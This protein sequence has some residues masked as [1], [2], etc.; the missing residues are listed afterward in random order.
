[1]CSGFVIVKVMDA[2]KETEMNIITMD[3][4]KVLNNRVMAER[5][6][7]MRAVQLAEAKWRE[8]YPEHRYPGRQLS[9][10]TVKVLHRA[11]TRERAQKQ[12]EYMKQFKININAQSNNGGNYNNG[13]RHNNRGHNNRQQE[14]KRREEERKRKKE[15][16]KAYLSRAFNLYAEAINGMIAEKY[17]DMQAA[18]EPVETKGGLPSSSASGRTIKRIGSGGTTTLMKS[19]SLTSGGSSLSKGTT[20]RLGE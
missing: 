4:Y 8:T 18:L 15:E 6:Y 9:S 7:H 17:P 11:P 16:K 2:F 1:M 10:R 20:K 13:N 19:G 5:M 14:E 12:I 3:E